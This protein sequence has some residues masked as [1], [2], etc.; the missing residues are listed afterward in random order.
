MQRSAFPR[1]LS[2]SNTGHRF[3]VDSLLLASFARIRRKDRRGL[4][5]GTG[6][7]VVGLALLLL[8]PDQNLRITAWISTRKWRATHR[9]MRNV[10]DSNSTS[11]Y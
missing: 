5:L 6:C 10:S 2:Q 7:G 1:G 4:D 8:H 11:T 3:S 9:S